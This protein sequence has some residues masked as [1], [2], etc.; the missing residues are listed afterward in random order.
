MSQSVTK[1]LIV[2]V[3]II[4]GL[5]LIFITNSPMGIYYKVHNP[6]SYWP[7][8]SVSRIVAEDIGGIILGVLSIVGALALRKDKRWAIFALPAI[9][10]VLV[11]AMLVSLVNAKGGLA[12]WTG[13][14]KILF[15]LIL[16]IFFIS[17]TAY[18]VFRKNA[19]LN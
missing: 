3:H 6:E 2:I 5:I 1:I 10:L 4:L 15:A 18:M 7:D 14:P 9:T 16:F 13:G 19:P 11:L 8:Y 17:E 12:A